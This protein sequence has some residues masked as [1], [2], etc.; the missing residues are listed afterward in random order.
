MQG[1]QNFRQRL[2]LRGIQEG[3]VFR[4]VSCQGG[5][6]VVEVNKNTIVIGQGMAQKITVRKIKAEKAKQ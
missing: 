3:T 4:V 1:G 5:P 6:V 2:L